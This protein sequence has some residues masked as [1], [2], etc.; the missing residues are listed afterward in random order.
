MPWAD[1]ETVANMGLPETTEA[2]LALAQVFIEIFSGTTEEASNEELISAMNLRR[3]SQAVA[4]Q[5]VWL[6]DHPDAV[7]AM[8]VQGVGL[9]PAH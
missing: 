8:D 9:D 1:L 6:D 7:K 5:A 3:L 2:Q 4:F